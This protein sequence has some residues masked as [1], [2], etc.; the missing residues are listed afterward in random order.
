MLLGDKNF[1]TDLELIFIILD[2]K[3]DWNHIQAPRGSLE[4]ICLTLG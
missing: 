2:S 4:E 1:A 3:V